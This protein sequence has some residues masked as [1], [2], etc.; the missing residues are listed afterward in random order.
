MR[1]HSNAQINVGSLIR[2]KHIFDES[3]NNLV[4]HWQ[5]CYFMHRGNQPKSRICLCYHFLLVPKYSH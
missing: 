5:L 2:E 3:R 1:F 4:I